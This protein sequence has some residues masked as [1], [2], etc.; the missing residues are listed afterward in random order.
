VRSALVS[1]T[2]AEF[3]VVGFD[4]SGPISQQDR[5]AALALVEA[6]SE[7]AAPPVILAE[8]TKCFAVTKSREHDVIDIQATLAGMVDGLR[9][10]PADVIRDGC[11]AYARCEKWRPSL[12]ELREYCWSRFRVRSSIRSALQ[13]AI[14]IEDLPPEV[15]VTPEDRAKVA[16]MIADA[17]SNMAVMPERTPQAEAEAQSPQRLSS[18]ARDIVRRGMLGRVIAP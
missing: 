12:A 3:A 16:A 17:R 15:K 1:K 8:V 18:E 11:R 6:A 2:N 4:L 14:A 7:P 13:R 5:H 10:F 9:E